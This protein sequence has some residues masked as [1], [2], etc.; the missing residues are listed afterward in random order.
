[1]WVLAA[2]AG[3]PRPW[4]RLGRLYRRLWPIRLREVVDDLKA[5]LSGRLSHADLSSY[6]AVQRLL[7]GG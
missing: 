7:Y 5:A 2:N 6:N 4:A 1:M 3:L